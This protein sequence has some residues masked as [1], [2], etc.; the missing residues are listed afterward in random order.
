MG[1]PPFFGCSPP[2]PKDSE[3]AQPEGQA[4]PKA[5]VG[6]KVG[7]SFE[8]SHQKSHQINGE[9]GWLMMNVNTRSIELFVFFCEIDWNVEWNSTGLMA[10]DNLQA[11]AKG[12]AKAETRPGAK[13]GESDFIVLFEVLPITL[14]FGPMKYWAPKEV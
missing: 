3:A 9:F 1:F 2:R 5:G 4:K 8:K 10:S 12:S 13:C 14:D 7:T 11:A 6:G